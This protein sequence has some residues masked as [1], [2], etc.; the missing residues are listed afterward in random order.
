MST[1]LLGQLF[2]TKA[3]LVIVA[4][5]QKIMRG[6]AC[7]RSTPIPLRLRWRSALREQERRFAAL[8]Q[9]FQISQVLMTACCLLVFL[10]V[11]KINEV[12][13]NS[14]HFHTNVRRVTF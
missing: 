5:D 8:F 1:K 7:H 9:V 11:L 6:A 12:D 10:E 13:R 14:I 3:R 2:R 4:Q